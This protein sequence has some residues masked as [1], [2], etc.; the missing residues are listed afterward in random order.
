MTIQKIYTYSYLFLVIIEQMV[1]NHMDTLKDNWPTHKQFY[2]AFI[3]L[4]TAAF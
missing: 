1:H 2:L 4:K 3:Y